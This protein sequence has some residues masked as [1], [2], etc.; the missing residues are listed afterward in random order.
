MITTIFFDLDGTLLPMDQEDF[1]K[2]YMGGLAKKMAPYGYE[3]DLLIRSIW[4]GTGA[5][6]ANDGSQ[7]NDQVFWNTFS[8]VCGRDTRADE[9]VFED[10]YR[11]EF[12][13]VKNACGFDE[14]A[15]ETIR[16]L[17][18][19]DYDT[20]LATNPLFPAI[21]THS[22]VRWAGM[23][24]SDFSYITTYENSFHCKPNP[25]YYRE[26]LDKLGLQPEQCLMVGN[27][28]GEDM[29]A[30]TLGMKVFLLTDCLINKTGEDTA[31][32]PHGSFP[33]LMEF[34]RSLS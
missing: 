26:I 19:M 25:D 27:D 3:S 7:R 23:E 12:Q 1:L 29:V 21:A 14:R 9:P 15:A 11:R 6:V 4:K 33:E 13:Q 20:V 22:R 28:V 34:V 2:A 24:P 32:Y 10:F 31:K 17:K 30:Q 8:A 5:M 18:A 16:E